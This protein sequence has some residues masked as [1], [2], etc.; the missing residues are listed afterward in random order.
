[1]CMFV[2]ILTQTSIKKFLVL[3]N[4]ELYHK[5]QRVTEKRNE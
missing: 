1:M 4:V 2:L 5:K 3:F